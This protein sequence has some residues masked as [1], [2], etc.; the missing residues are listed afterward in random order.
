MNY[1]YAVFD[2][3]QSGREKPQSVHRVLSAAK[4]AADRLTETFND[5]W[6]VIPWNSDKKGST[7]IQFVDPIYRGETA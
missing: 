3:N 7:Y 2:K 6:V 5:N 4:N 1:P